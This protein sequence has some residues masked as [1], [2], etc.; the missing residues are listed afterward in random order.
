MN[1]SVAKA[2]VTKWLKEKGKD[3]LD[4][5]IKVQQKVSVSPTQHCYMVKYIPKSESG[6]TEEDA[7]LLSYSLVIDPEDGVVEV[8]PYIDESEL[9]KEIKKVEAEE[10]PEEKF[11][12]AIE[13]KENEIEDAAS[14]PM[15]TNEIDFSMM[16]DEELDRILEKKIG[17]MTEDEKRKIASDDTFLNE[18]SKMMEDLDKMLSSIEERF[19]K[20]TSGKVKANSSHSTK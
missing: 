16:D 5:E 1:D 15:E 18:E 6:E 10:K 11:D 9:E 20:L 8:L 19:E 3:F 2:Y 13:M 12:A 7:K 4:Y 17:R 14:H